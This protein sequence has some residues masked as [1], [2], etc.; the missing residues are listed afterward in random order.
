MQWRG[1]GFVVLGWGDP[2]AGVAAV[3]GLVMAFLDVRWGGRIV[4]GAFFLGALIR[5]VARPSRKAGGLTVRSRTLD[6][7]ILLTLGIGVLIASATVNVRADVP[8][9]P[10]VGRSAR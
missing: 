3:G 1:S 5:F 7:V 6:V 10:S 2:I 4:A 8:D 9:R